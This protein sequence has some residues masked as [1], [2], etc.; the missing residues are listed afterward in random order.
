MRNS[1]ESYVNFCFSGDFREMS[2][3]ML[4]F[5]LAKTWNFYLPW[6]DSDFSHTDEK[7]LNN[8][9]PVP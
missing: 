1:T 4:W 3:V 9:V 8:K 6:L 2:H 7:N 5:D